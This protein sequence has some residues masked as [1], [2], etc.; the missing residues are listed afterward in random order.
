[1]HRDIKLANV[2]V[3]QVTPVIRVKLADFGLARICEEV[4]L[5]FETMR[6]AHLLPGACGRDCTG[7]S[8]VL[9]TRDP[10]GRVD[11][12]IR[13]ETTVLAGG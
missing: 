4:R 3:A 8:A 1:M 6:S 2:M 5:T 7:H 13:R 10:A 12:Q 11:K 9:G